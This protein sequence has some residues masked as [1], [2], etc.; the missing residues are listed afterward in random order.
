MGQGVGAG[1]AIVR[2]P[3]VGC[4]DH[5]SSPCSGR[6]RHVLGRRKAL[7][8]PSQAGGAVSFHRREKRRYNGPFACAAKRPDDGDP[9]FPTG[10]TSPSGAECH[11]RSTRSA[12]ACRGIPRSLGHPGAQEKKERDMLLVGGSNETRRKTA[13]GIFSSGD[14]LDRDLQLFRGRTRVCAVRDAPRRRG[15]QVARD[16][17]GQLTAAWRQRGREGLA[18]VLR[19]DATGLPIQIRWVWFEIETP[20]ADRPLA[21][22]E[23]IS[24]VTRGELLSI[25]TSDAAGQRRLH[26]YRPIDLGAARPGGLE[27]TGSLTPLD[28]HRREAAYVALLSIGAMAAAGRPGHLGRGRCVGWCARC[29][30]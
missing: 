2:D 7:R 3:G 29:S 16:L 26:T 13:V 5:R 28:A 10:A 21:P 14:S 8:V 18:D 4:T 24:A 22:L 30:N 20:A 11:G 25:T 15:R 6:V 23:R 9:G 12:P 27:L 19:Q 1:P 17:H